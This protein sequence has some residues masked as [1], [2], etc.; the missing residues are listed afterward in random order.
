MLQ[1]LEDGY[2]WQLL[3]KDIPKDLHKMWS[4]RQSERFF[5]QGQ[6]KANYSSTTFRL[7][8]GSIAIRVL[9]HT[10]RDACW[11]RQTETVSSCLGI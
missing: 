9:K 6:A 3:V 1:P 10:M 2:V 8:N 4:K 7:C 11:A 5:V